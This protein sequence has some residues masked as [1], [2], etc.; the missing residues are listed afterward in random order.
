MYWALIDVDNCYCSVE[1]SFRPDLN[2]K[3]V[4][5]LSNNDG[6][7]VAR[8]NEAK[9]LGIKA[10]TPAY[11][12][13]ELFPGKEIYEFSSN[14]ELIADM[15]RRL[16]NIV[17]QACPEFHRYSVDEGFCKLDGMDDVDL[18]AWGEDLHRRIL[19]GLG[20]PVSIGIARTKTLAKVASKFAKHYPGYR[21]C[22]WID[23]DE[24]RLKALR[25]FPI[26]DVWGIGRRW[27]EKLK[28]YQKTTA[29]DF[30]LSPESWVMGNFN[31][32][33]LR[34]WKELNGVDCIPIDD[35]EGVTKKSI[36]TSRSFPGMI[37]NLRDL[38]THV[39]NY[40]AR[41]AEKLRRQHSVACVVGVFIDTNPFREDLPQ[42]NMFGSRQLLTPSNATEEI[43]KESLLCL[44]GI[45]RP[46]YRYKR[47]GVIIL[48]IAPDN[49]V[50]PDMFT[51][52]P[53]R[54]RK[55]QRL[56]AV[57]DRINRVNGSETIVLG[58]QQYTAK[59]GRGKANVFANAIRHDR[60]SPNYT[61]RW[62]DILKVS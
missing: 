58:S 57:V 33:G 9:A 16:M 11:Q 35:M 27:A 43:V 36:C 61:T 49:G 17:R 21:H 47:A 31:V 53:T 26:E 12:L 22:C 2:G 45:F 46:G 59:G 34:T 29:L 62:S 37:A 56:D 40:A 44:Q 24:K 7:V 23:S 10:G 48:E 54:Y 28:G 32:V 20:M 6:C 50:L 41:C 30:A 19:R 13:P 5:V 1:R 25:L 14:Y 55:L 3:A 38:K 4:V 42:Y 18:K 51:F 39:A 15:T 52:D 8:S 60:R